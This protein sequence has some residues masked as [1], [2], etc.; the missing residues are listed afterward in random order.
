[1]GLENMR[2]R[3]GYTYSDGSPDGSPDRGNGQTG[4]QSDHTLHKKTSD[5]RLAENTRF[6]H[7]VPLNEEQIGEQKALIRAEARHLERAMDEQGDRNIRDSYNKLRYPPMVFGALTGAITGAKA[8]A[9]FSSDPKKI[10]G[11]AVVGAA[12]MAYVV[13]SIVTPEKQALDE[14]TRHGPHGWLSKAGRAIRDKQHKMAYRHKVEDSAQGLGIP[15]PNIDSPGWKNLIKD[16][17]SDILENYG[18]DD[19]MMNQILLIDIVE[20]GANHGISEEDRQS[21]EYQKI[22]NAALKENH[23]RSND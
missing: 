23:R 5:E 14:L 20:G 8:V 4:R 2:H 12:A 10:V 11:G 1:M 15:A 13:D 17:Y 7:H 18:I 21:P 16:A 9:D 22:L 19:N 6:L 3:R